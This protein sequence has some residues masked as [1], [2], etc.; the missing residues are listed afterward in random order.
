VSP[1]TINIDVDA[2]LD[3]G[4]VSLPWHGLMT[5]IGIVLAAAL[6]SRFGAERGLDRERIFD[7]AL[8]T[9]LAGILGARVLYLIEQDPG[10]LVDP[11]RWLGS[12]G[13]SF[14]GAVVLGPLAAYIYMRRA[15]IGLVYL[16]ALAAGFGLGLAVGRIG[17]IL[18]GEHHGPPSQL[19]WAISYSNPEA[20]VPSPD[21]A[22]HPGA[23]YE[24]LLGLA[25]FAL[26]WPLRGRFRIPGLLFAAVVGLY[27]LGRFG[28]FFLRSDSDDLALGLSNSQ[29]LSL[30]V[31]AGAVALAWWLWRRIAAPAPSGQPEAP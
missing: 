21:V 6:A 3:L 10:A 5:A 29:W 9:A 8:V 19:P 26:I 15:G 22:Y 2:V 17:D 30:A 31:L 23:L 24:A 4:P 1:A 16:D 12:E 20:N 7:L 14:Y 18:I 27:G 28:I 25:I 11:E 13:F